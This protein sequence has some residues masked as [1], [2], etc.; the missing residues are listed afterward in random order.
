MSPLQAMNVP[1]NTPSILLVRVIVS[2]A[3]GGAIPPNNQLNDDIDTTSRHFFV[4][5]WHLG[6]RRR[7][8]MLLDDE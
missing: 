8:T 1:T 7:T 3:I 2:F 4:S 5:L 6:I